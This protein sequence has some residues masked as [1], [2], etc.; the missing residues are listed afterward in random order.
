MPAMP[1]YIQDALDKY[2]DKFN[3]PFPTYQANGF[4]EA[5]KDINIC[6]ERGITAEEFK[7]ELYGECLGKNF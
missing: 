3:S 1:T 5:V 2:Y 4:D 7:P 6:I